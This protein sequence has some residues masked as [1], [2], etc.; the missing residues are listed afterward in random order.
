MRSYINAASD[1]ELTQQVSF[2]LLS[3]VQGQKA[4]KGSFRKLSGC[5]LSCNQASSWKKVSCDFIF[6][7]FADPFWH[8]A[9]KTTSYLFP[10]FL[11]QASSSCCPE[12]FPK[13]MASI[14]PALM[15]QLVVSRWASPWSSRLI[16][17][18]VAEVSLCFHA[19]STGGLQMIRDILKHCFWW[20]FRKLNYQFPAFCFN[21]LIGIEM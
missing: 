10:P 2:F 15:K 12:G 8:D 13:D 1:V 16:A 6:C 19:H 4:T 21:S 17:A 18:E 11:K 5:L 3:F 14:L 7:F 20:C 9:L